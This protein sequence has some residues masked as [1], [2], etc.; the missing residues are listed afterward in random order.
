[1]FHG[2]QEGQAEMDRLRAMRVFA[3]IIDR[4][5]LSATAETL[6]ISL[7]S[8][9]RVLSALERELG[10]RLI[11]RTT[12]GLTETDAGRLYYRRCLTILEEIR[13]AETAV[14][15]HAKAPAGELRLTAPVTFGRYHVAPSLAEFLERYP[16]LSFYLLL[17]DHCESLT[18]QRLDVAVRVAVLQKDTVTARRLGY[19]QRA[20]VGSRDYFSRYPVPSHPR[21]LAQHNC[22]H[23]T[24]YLRADEWTFQ[25][26]GRKI[27]VRVKG[28]LRTNNQ[29]ALLDAVLAGAGLAVLP[30]WLAHEA[31]N[32]GRLLRVLA[33]YEAPRTPVYAV[34]SAQGPPPKKVR[35]F[36]EFLGEHYREKGILS[37]D[38]V[39]AG[40]SEAADSRLAEEQ[41][42][43]SPTDAESISR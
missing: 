2:L 17:S 39:V 18:E 4:R 31:L 34:F 6:G 36:V 22:M 10:V 27:T 28:R 16:R 7:P 15:S 29:E 23:F 30:T 41:V 12:R 1:L 32:R 38:A 33:Q 35:V 3:T 19:V 5:S 9:S 40:P 8:V 42:L 26:Q 20:V 14:Q 11:A 25:E 13:E 37:S 43:E 21:E 24:H